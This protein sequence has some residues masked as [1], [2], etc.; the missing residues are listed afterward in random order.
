MPQKS[1]DWKDAQQQGNCGIHI[2]IGK[3]KL[4]RLAEDGVLDLDKDIQYR[5]S[6]GSSEG[7]A[8]AFVGLRNVPEDEE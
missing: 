3:K 6:V 2:Y 5:P 1:A 4:Q 7:R 8:R